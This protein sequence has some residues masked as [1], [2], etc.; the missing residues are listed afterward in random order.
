MVKIWEVEL[1]FKLGES[2][3][4]YSKRSTKERAILISGLKIPEMVKSLSEHRALTDA[5]K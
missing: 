5:K 2:E 4:T 1:M 3:D